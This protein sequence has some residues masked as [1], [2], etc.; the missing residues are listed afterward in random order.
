[1]RDQADQLRQM[2]IRS[3]RD[4]DF[5]AGRLRKL[6]VM[7]GKAGVGAS[8]VAVNLAVALAE[9]GCRTVLVDGDLQCAHATALCGLDSP[10]GISDVL[11]GRLTIHEVVERGP[12]GIQV[13]PGHG[14]QAMSADC[15]PATQERLVEQ[16]DSLAAHADIAVVDAGQAHTHVARRFWRAADDVLLITTPEAAAITGAYAA[17]KVS[18]ADDGPC[19][20]TVVNLSPSEAFGCAIYARLSL[21]CNRFL[22]TRLAYAGHLPYHPPAYELETGELL[23]SNPTSD[24]AMQFRKLAGSLASGTPGRAA[25]PGRWLGTRRRVAA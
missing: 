18:V 4:C 19:V 6:V 14:Q 7:G 1:M 9:N 2:A 21:A 15:S 10:T 25:E 11:A 20:R 8:T 24:L 13:L 16:L 22:S 12:A 17:M 3:A 5:R 23:A